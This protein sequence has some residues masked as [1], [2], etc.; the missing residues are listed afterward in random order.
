MPFPNQ[1]Q[2][3]T[4]LGNFL[5][6]RLMWVTL[7]YSTPYQ[8]FTG[9][10]EVMVGLLLLYRRTITLGVCLATGVFLNVVMLNLCYDIPVKLFS[11][12]LLACCLLLLSYDLQRMIDFFIFNKA[13]AG[14]KF[15]EFTL[16]KRWMR[17]SRVGI[18][19]VFIYLV[20][21]MPFEN[22]Y[23]S[24]RLLNDYSIIK[25]GIY[26]V[27]TY[28]I[29]DT[30][31]SIGNN[32][33]SWTNM[34]FESTRI[35]SVNDTTTMFRQRYG[36]GYFSYE[37]DSVKKMITFRKM[38]DDDSQIFTTHYNLKGSDTIQLRTRINN[39][40]LYL[41]LTRTNTQFPLT[42]HQFHWLSETTR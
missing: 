7:G 32:E 24:S 35:G 21:V 1:S 3:L 23:S 25:P 37:I 34:A 5:P 2:L 29:D 13:V 6:M 26:Q 22:A 36:R 12:N 10:L 27:H 41:L 11:L 18:K 4:P 30:M 39:D 40:S 15:Y 28:A 42:E 38:P 14:N 19:A 31:H 17:V 20:I 33:T 8:I 9:V 16:H